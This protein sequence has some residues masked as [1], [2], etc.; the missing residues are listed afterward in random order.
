MSYFKKQRIK[1]I[2]AKVMSEERQNLKDTLDHEDV[3]DVVHAV[4]SA[5]AGG[6]QCE[7]P[8]EN[9]VV[10]ID[11]VKALK[12]GETTRGLEVIDHPTGKVV[13]L[14]DRGKLKERLRRSIR[15]SIRRR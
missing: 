14:E 15:R 7:T 6:N 11:H 4:H 3:E 13:S 5:W 1:R 12:N 9:L 8:D 2:I 10:H